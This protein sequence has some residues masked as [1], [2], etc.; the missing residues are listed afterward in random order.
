MTSIRS[1]LKNHNFQFHDLL[2]VTNDFANDVLHG[3]SK[4][5][6]SIPPKYFYDTKGSQLFDAITKLPEYYQT[7]TEIALL[8]ENV[9]EIARHVGA[10]SLLI[11]PGGGSCTKVHILLDGLKPAA[12]VPMDISNQHLQ[13]AT[14]KLAIAYPELGFHAIC[15]DFTQTM[16]LPPTVSDRIDSVNNTDVT[17]LAF[18][19]GSSIGNFNPKNAVEFLISIAKMVES[20]GFLLIGV[21]L[22][23]DKNILQAAYNDTA[24]ITAQFNLNLLYRINHELDADFDLSN[25]QHKAFYNEQKERI[26]M[27]L[28]SLCE[29]EVSIG[30]RIFRFTN[31]ET[32]HSENSYKYTIDN[33]IQLAQQAGF[34]SIA[35]WSDEGKLFSIHLFG[36]N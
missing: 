18:F 31:G 4:R 11:E 25:W 33:F 19:P 10:G 30:Q 17:K 5:P 24:N 36:V 16:K 21:D 9:E 20:G 2:S 7:R 23:K 26:E 12:Y 8:Q 13:Q 14:K 1:T 35:Q 15:T 32:I 6:A 27:H 34:Q 29:Q 22:I 28:V 3:L